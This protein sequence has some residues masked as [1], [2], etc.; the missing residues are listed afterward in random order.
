MG[1]PGG[2]STQ[3]DVSGDQPA[4]VRVDTLNRYHTPGSGKNRERGQ[5]LEGEVAG[6]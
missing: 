4:L 2:I 3:W 1:G 6:C 5:L